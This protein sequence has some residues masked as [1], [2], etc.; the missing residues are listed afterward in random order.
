LIRKVWRVEGREPC[1]FVFGERLG[2]ARRGAPASNNG[3]YIRRH[4]PPSHVWSYDFA[5][6]QTHDGCHDKDTY[7]V[8]Q[9]YF[10]VDADFWAEFEEQLASF[11]SD[12][13]IED[14]S[15]FLVTYAAEDWSDVCLP[16]T[17]SGSIDDE[18]RRGPAEQ[19]AGR[20]VESADSSAHPCPV[21]DAFGLRCNSR[22]RPQGSG[23]DGPRRR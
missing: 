21:T 6:V 8:V 11:D 9:R 17:R 22:C 4:E 14:A 10:D 12:T 19:R 3:S 7:D 13:L 5:S 16:K 2:S 23:A 20:A 15:D 1:V 18:G